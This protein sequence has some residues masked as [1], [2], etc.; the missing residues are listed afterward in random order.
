MSVTEGELDNLS[1]LRDRS[2]D[3]EA[4]MK[5]ALSRLAASEADCSRLRSELERWRKAAGDEEDKALSAQA[6][7]RE[8]KRRHAESLQDL[9]AVQSECDSLKVKLK[10]SAGIVAAL[11]EEKQ[12]TRAAIQLR[13]QA[14]HNERTKL[15]NLECKLHSMEHASNIDRQSLLS[16]EEELNRQKV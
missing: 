12:G 3:L 10:D 1:V 14:V 9:K 5:S 4:E 7:L 8:A 16:K 2:E 15:Q 13:D 11:T 6:G